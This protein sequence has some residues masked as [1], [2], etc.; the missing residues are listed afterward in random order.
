MKRIFWISILI[1]SM[2]ACDPAEDFPEGEKLLVIDGWIEQGASAQV[3]TS[4]TSSFLTELDSISALSFMEAKAK[5]TVSQFDVDEILTLRPSPIYFPP[6]VYQGQA[7]KGVTGKT[8]KLEVSLKNHIYTATATIPPAPIVDSVW[9]EAVNDSMGIIRIKIN[10]PASE[11][12]YYRIYTQRYILDSHPIP[13]YLPNYSDDLFNGKQLEIPVF[14]GS[15]SNLDREKGLYFNLNDFVLVKVCSMDKATYD[16]WNQVQIQLSGSK[17]P[18]A[19]HGKSLPTNLSNNAIGFWCA[20]GVY[21][22]WVMP[23]S[24]KRK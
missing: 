23:S 16:Y 17:N 1:Y 5:V 8:Y 10:D 19:S 3:I 12:N 7:I 9:M 20:Y 18:F 13:A 22:K 11:H 4:Y 24:L 15:A 6:L 21:K 14:R 2:F